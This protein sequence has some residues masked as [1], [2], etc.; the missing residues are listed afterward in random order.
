LRLWSLEEGKKNLH[1][2]ESGESGCVK[3]NINIMNGGNIFK[4]FDSI[5]SFWSLIVGIEIGIVIGGI[6]MWLLRRFKCVNETTRHPVPVRRRRSFP[7]LHNRASIIFRPRNVSEENTALWSD[8]D[9]LNC[10][11][12]PPPPYRYHSD[13]SPR[14]NSA[15]HQRTDWTLA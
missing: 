14:N 12:T 4:I 1:I 7:S 5:P 6:G 13:R 15:R 2:E 11:D 3:R 9:T 8:M 10:P